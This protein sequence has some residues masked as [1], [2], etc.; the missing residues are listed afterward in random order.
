MPPPNL[1]RPR[2]SAAAAASANGVGA[3]ATGSSSRV[4]RRKAEDTTSHEAGTERSDRRGAGGGA[5]AGGNSGS[6]NFGVGMVKGREEEY[7]EAGEV[8]TKVRYRFL[9]PWLR[10]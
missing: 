3:T 4:K 10:Q 5:G 2:Q 9:L 6:V 1:K 8:H 7:G